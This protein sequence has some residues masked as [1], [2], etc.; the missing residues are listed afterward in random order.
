MIY[1]INMTRVSSGIDIMKGYYSLSDADLLVRHY[2][3]GLLCFVKY[4][5]QGFFNSQIEARAKCF[6][7]ND[8]KIVSEINSTKI[9]LNYTNNFFVYFVGYLKLIRQHKFQFYTRSCDSSLC[10]LNGI[11][12]C[13]HYGLHSAS[14]QKGTEVWLTQ[15]YHKIEYFFNN[16]NGNA[17]FEFGEFTDNYR[18]LDSYYHTDGDYRL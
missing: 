9:N 7:F 11:D 17:L 13:S 12:V 2:K 15:G 8:P 5:Q 4:E 1:H 18:I 16:L 14:Y 3:P 10:L 6:G